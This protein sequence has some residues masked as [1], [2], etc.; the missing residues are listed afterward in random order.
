MKK[1][2]GRPPKYLNIWKQEYILN[3]AAKLQEK[4]QKM[5]H[6]EAAMDGTNVLNSGEQ[7]HD[8]KVFNEAMERFLGELREV[9]RL[10]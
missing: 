8:C 10:A 9:Y 7:H 4:A 6:E 2:R 3:M 1:R 5:A